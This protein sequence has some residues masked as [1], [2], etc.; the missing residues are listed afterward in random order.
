MTLWDSQLYAPTRNAANRIDEDIGP[1]VG[2]HSVVITDLVTRARIRVCSVHLPKMLTKRWRRGIDGG[3]LGLAF[4]LDTAGDDV[5]AVTLPGDFNATTQELQHN[6]HLGGVLWRDY[7]PCFGDGGI[8]DIF[9]SRPLIRDEA[10]YAAMQ[11]HFTHRTLRSTA[12]GDD[13]RFQHQIGH[14]LFD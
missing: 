6:P 9:M 11:T 4:F 3:R 14:G 2:Y 8:E 5:D 1:D 12:S 13:Q 10:L 7:R